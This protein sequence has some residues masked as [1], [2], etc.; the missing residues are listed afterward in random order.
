VSVP[1]GKRA[2][3][4]RLVGVAAAHRSA[5]AFGA[6]A[7]VGVLAMRLA[8]PWPLRGVVE[9]VFPTAVGEGAPLGVGLD[10][11]GGPVTAF[12]L[13]YFLLAV[14]TGSFEWAQRVW[15]ARAA[16][17]SA[18]DLRAAAVEAAG[19]GA[20]RTIDRADLITRIIGDSARL[21]ADLKGILVHLTKNALLLLAITGLFLVLAPRL[22]L[23]FLLSGLLATLIGYFA[24]E[25]VAETAS[26]QRRKESKYA[27]TIRPEAVESSTGSDARRLNRSSAKKEVRITRII[28]RS[29][30]LIHAAVAATLGLAF[31]TGVQDVRYGSLVPGEL[32]LFI[33]YAITIQRRAVMIG[34]QVARGGKLLATAERLG[35]LIESG[36]RERASA[37]A[38]LRGEIRLDGAR[39]RR[40]AVGPIHLTIAHGTRVLVLG[41]DGAGKSSLLRLIAAREPA[42]HG[43]VLWDGK[44]IED[45]SAARSAVAYWSDEVEF[46]GLT[47]RLLLGLPPRGEPGSNEVRLLEAQG[48]W[49][50]VRRLEHGLDHPLSSL[51]LSRRERR[52]LALGGILMGDAPVWVLDEPV[53]ADVAGERARLGAVLE[54]GAKR[55]VVVGLRRPVCVDSFDRVVVLRKGKI[56]FEGTP[57]EWRRRRRRIRELRQA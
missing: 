56:D 32:F 37:P 47:P 30:L 3:L 53:E 48:A 28:G 6:L 42:R 39:A 22:G 41:G 31:W 38:V 21:K 20:A 7:T 10:I 50:V 44:A 17:L 55:T 57:E 19:H 40:S 54:R 26:R 49:K 24:V 33:A 9:H 25:E 52:A 4:R 8:L 13:I 46:G 27:S 5:L 2:A 51:E 15:M 11:P 34:R 18:H 45:A 43:R 29:T 16:S 1:V 23:L 12:C 35:G 14:A 36:Q